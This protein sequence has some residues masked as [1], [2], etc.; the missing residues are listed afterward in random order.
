[1]TFSFPRPKALYVCCSFH[2]HVA[3]GQSTSS[4]PSPLPENALHCL[5]V[6]DGSPASGQL[7]PFFDY[8]VDVN[9]DGAASS[10]SLSQ[11]SHINVRRLSKLLEEHEGRRIGLKVYNAKSQRI[12]GEFCTQGNADD[13]R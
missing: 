2:L 6:A 13:Q 9:E 10:S 4:L 12:R 11:S 5:R 8:L 7:E 3:M 1:M